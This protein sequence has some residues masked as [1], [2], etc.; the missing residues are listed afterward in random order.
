[1]ALFGTVR[2]KAEP[3]AGWVLVWLAA[4][5]DDKPNDDPNLAQAR[6]PAAKT[7]IAAM[8]PRRLGL[9]QVADLCRL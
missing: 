5:A 8:K 7:S 6:T 3:S 1:V 2:A 9:E 4:L